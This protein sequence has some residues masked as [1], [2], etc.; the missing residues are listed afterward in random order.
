M[1]T[2]SPSS[3][4]ELN[5]AYA[6]DRHMQT[7]KF[8]KCD[9]SWLQS[10]EDQSV[11]GRKV[12][13]IPFCDQHNVCTGVARWPHGISHC[14]GYVTELRPSQLRN[15]SNRVVVVQHLI[16]DDL[17]PNASL[18]RTQSLR[19][20]WQKHSWG[21]FICRKCWSDDRCIEPGCQSRPGVKGERHCLIVQES[22]WLRTTIQICCAARDTIRA[23]S[24][25]RRHRTTI[26][27]A[28]F[29][30]TNKK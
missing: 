22:T 6:L 21:N 15:V 2:A 19:Q 29:V 11:Q 24:V 16:V 5:R 18:C 25:V 17:G 23:P 30:D 26:S 20:V 8:D 9:H 10:T 27:F 1:Q 14:V 12:G 4:Y 7:R 28:G 13:Q 3:G